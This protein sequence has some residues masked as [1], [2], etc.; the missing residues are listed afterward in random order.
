MVGLPIPNPD[1]VKQFQALYERKFGVVLT[2]AEALEVTTKALQLY[3]ILNHARLPE[4]TKP[5]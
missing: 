3:Y 1:E 5:H 2:E 4:D